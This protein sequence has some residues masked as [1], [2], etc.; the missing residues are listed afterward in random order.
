[1]FTA[2]LKVLTIITCS[3]F[4]LGVWLASTEC[5]KVALICRKTVCISFLVQCCFWSRALL[6]V[7]MSI[8]YIAFL[9]WYGNPMAATL[10]LICRCQASVYMSTYEQAFL[11]NQGFTNKDYTTFFPEYCIS[12]VCIRPSE[13]VCFSVF[14][15]TC[16]LCLRVCLCVLPIPGP[17]VLNSP[18]HLVTMPLPWP[19]DCTS[20][21][22]GTAAV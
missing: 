2:A 12:C 9:E 19:S 14:L 8:I 18:W 3:V 4:V 17:H 1:M 5:C 6:W 10:S 7:G 16:I 20:Q 21:A 13:C 15:W 11:H 22:M